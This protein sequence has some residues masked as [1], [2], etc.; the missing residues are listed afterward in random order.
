MPPLV[1][2]VGAGA[3]GLQCARALLRTGLSVT[4]L[5][6]A[7]GLGGFWAKNYYGCVSQV[8]SVYHEF[9]EFPFP[10]RVR[11]EKFLTCEA[12]KEYMNL[13]AQQFD[14]LPNINFK[15][16]LV[17]LSQV[18]EDK[19][20]VSYTA[21]RQDNRLCRITANFVI[22]CTGSRCK[23][24]IPSFPG[25]DSFLGQQLHS[26]SF[27][28]I[29]LARHKHV[30]IVG[31]GKSAIDCAVKCVPV[32][33]SV[34]LVFR[35]AHWLLPRSLVDKFHKRFL[36]KVLPP[37]YTA[38]NTDKLKHK[39]LWPMRTLYWSSLQTTLTWKSKLSGDWAPE[40]GVLRDTFF[41]GQFHG[42]SVQDV[43][44]SSVEVVRGFVSHLTPSGIEM[45]DGRTI[46]ADLVIYGTG[47]DR[48]YDFFDFRAKSKLQLQPDGL[49]LYRSIIPPLLKNLAFI[50]CEA[51]TTNGVLTSALQS[52]WLRRAF[53]GSLK[54]PGIQSMFK[55][56]QAQM[57]W[58]RKRMPARRYRGGTIL[59][60]TQQYHDQLVEDIGF[61]AKR[62]GF[63]LVK[64][65][66]SPYTAADYADV[67]SEPLDI[68]HPTSQ[69][70]YPAEQP[71]GASVTAAV[72][73][74]TSLYAPDNIPRPSAQEVDNHLRMIA[75]SQHLG[76]DGHD[77]AA[78]GALDDGLQIRQDCSQRNSTQQSDGLLQAS[79][80]GSEPIARSSI[81]ESELANLGSQSSYQ[82]SEQSLGVSPQQSHASGAA[83]T[84]GNSVYALED[85]SNVDA[86]RT[87]RSSVNSKGSTADL[88]SCPSVE[89]QVSDTLKSD[90]IVFDIEQDTACETTS[91]A[92]TAAPVAE[93][94]LGD[95]SY[96]VARSNPLAQA[97]TPSGSEDGFR[98]RDSGLPEYCGDLG[99]LGSGNS[100]SIPADFPV[101]RLVTAVRNQSL[102]EH[103]VQRTALS[104]VSHDGSVI[105]L[106]SPETIA[107][108]SGRAGSAGEL[109][110]QP[111]SSGSASRSFHGKNLS[112]K[113]FLHMFEQ[114]RHKDQET[115]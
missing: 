57:R 91:A 33:R 76:L 102:S 61:S 37:Y 66:W 32:A 67:F 29:N 58:R 21:G 12:L 99:S 108:T 70:E 92:A 51:S 27:S 14:V 114:S 72:S 9:P 113:H 105:V 89:R 16:K 26:Q 50:G 115:L 56:I 23:P 62:K 40:S 75:I 107:N 10:P 83:S 63:N 96:M 65:L 84:V 3:A 48:N 18:A 78:E 88:G 55:D 68:F 15:C 90:T 7:D 79:G 80:H 8:P 31:S 39:L 74:R 54:L 17:H 4:V 11:E 34:T 60:Y 100:L 109:S 82:H 106:P 44:A 1:V 95:P 86:L 93:A 104:H 47:F 110:K 22:L 94:S 42:S 52:E 13:Y 69:N 81:A 87:S 2:V 35:Q 46:Q 53:V 71:A 112:F 97:S 30:V 6:Q 73:T 111:S 20:Q 5:E 43:L 98:S 101:H 36:C 85:T 49:Y 28:D 25:A 38:T 103:L 41:G 45:K 19:W 77:L 24:Y 59:L 64:E